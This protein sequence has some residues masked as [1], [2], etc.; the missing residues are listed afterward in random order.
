MILFLLKGIFLLLATLLVL[1]ILIQIIG[2]LLPKRI[3]VV[4]T[5][6][7]FH[8]TETVQRILTNFTD[9][10]SWKPSVTHTAQEDDNHWSEEIGKRFELN[11]VTEPTNSPDH[12][13]VHTVGK[14]LPFQLQRTYKVWKQDHMVFLQVEDV[15][16]I[17]KPYLRALSSLFYDHKAFAK[18]EL[19]AIDHYLDTKYGTRF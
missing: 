9:Y 6:S 13:Q 19:H 10:P 3:H 4:T 18:Q 11:Y 17:N 12:I 16:I 5:Q 1:A 7:Y 8:S 2:Y 15:L 14:Q